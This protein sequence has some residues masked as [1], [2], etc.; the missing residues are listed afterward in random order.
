MGRAGFTG[1]S[2]V[3]FSLVFSSIQFHFLVSTF[4]RVLPNPLCCSNGLVPPEETRVY[5]RGLELFIAQKDSCFSFSF[6][7]LGKG[8]FWEWLFCFESTAMAFN[9][10]NF[11]PSGDRWGGFLV[12]SSS[13]SF[14][15]TDTLSSTSSS[16]S[17]SLHTV[18]G[19]GKE[20][21]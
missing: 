11:F 6:F 8:G 16:S 1:G 5:E 14:S 17:S 13:S 7:S 3:P 12:V 21:S 20:L 2:L 9:V 15:N 18:W 4:S 10:L 19:L